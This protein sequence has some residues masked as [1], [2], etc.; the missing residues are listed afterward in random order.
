MILS[1]KTPNTW[2]PTGSNK[3]NCCDDLGRRLGANQH[4][5]SMSRRRLLGAVTTVESSS[6]LVVFPTEH[7]PAHR[8]CDDIKHIFDVLFSPSWPFS[9]VTD[10]AFI[11]LVCGEFSSSAG[12]VAAMPSVATRGNWEQGWEMKLMHS[13][14]QLCDRKPP[15]S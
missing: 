8:L 1:P 13:C 15:S 9:C 4:V 14:L 2:K 7:V 11:T 12:V 5:C 6:F 10:V 3:T